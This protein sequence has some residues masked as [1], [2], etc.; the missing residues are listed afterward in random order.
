MRLSFVFGFPL[1][2]QLVF[3]PGR[4]KKR[5]GEQSLFIILPTLGRTLQGN[6]I[7]EVEF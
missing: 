7:P 4:S 1:N 2:K 6:L 3:L 5:I